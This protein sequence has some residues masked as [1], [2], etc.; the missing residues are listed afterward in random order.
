[1]IDR[2]ARR[3]IDIRTRASTKP[4]A[5]FVQIHPA[6]VLGQSQ[7]S[8]EAGQAASDDSDMRL[9]G[10]GVVYL[11]GLLPILFA[12]VLCIARTVLSMYA[13]ACRA[14]FEFGR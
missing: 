1:M 8:R 12:A 14:G 3:A 5:S 6:A 9:C 10:D 11:N 4:L 7:G 13:F 2:L